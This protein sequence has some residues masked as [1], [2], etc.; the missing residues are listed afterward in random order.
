MGY[1]WTVRRS[2]FLG[3]WF[4]AQD[5][6]VKKLQ[7]Q[8]QTN[9]KLPKHDQYTSDGQIRLARL[10]IIESNSNS[11][12]LS[13]LTYWL[14]S[15]SKCHKQISSWTNSHPLTLQIWWWGSQISL[16]HEYIFH[17]C[18]N[19]GIRPCFWRRADIQLGILS[20]AFTYYFL[21][22]E[23]MSLY[24]YHQTKGA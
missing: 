10:N 16:K 23:S 9:K 21:S 4:S 18:I 11:P 14:M 17:N 5:G 2:A 20:V 1:G 19:S 12:G 24:L 8:A 13:G 3:L 15:L 7:T 22:V 6:W